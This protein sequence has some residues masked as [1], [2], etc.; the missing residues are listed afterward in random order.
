MPIMPL[1][2]TC[3][4]LSQLKLMRAT[5]LF[6]LHPGEFSFKIQPATLVWEIFY[7]T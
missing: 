3:F 6:G 4:S 5:V 2:V 1:Q 7:Y